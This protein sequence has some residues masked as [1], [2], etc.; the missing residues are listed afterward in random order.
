MAR[1]VLPGLRPAPLASYLAGLGLIRMLGEQADPNLTARWTDGGLV[2]TTTVEDTAAWL[3]DQYVPTPVLSPWNEGSGFGAKDRTPKQTLA[4]LA[5]HPSPRLDA[6]RRALP[7]ATSVGEKYR[8]SAGWTKA[9]AVREF[10]N[11]CPDEL[12]PWIDAAVVLAADQVHFPPLLGT[13]GNDGRLD[14]STTFH[15]RLLDVLDP[16]IRDRARS[17]GQARDL[18]AGTQT[19]RLHR[20]PVGQFDPAAAG[21]RSSSP[22]G[23]ADSV[24]NPWQFILLVEGALLFASSATRRH[25]HAAGRAAMPFTVFAAPDGSAS[26]AAGETSRGEVW[27]PVWEE[28]FTLAEVRQLFA[29]ARASWRGR[30]ARQAVEFYAATRTLG[31]A[32]GVTG[33]VRYGLHQRNGLAYVAVPVEHLTVRSS[34]EV[35]LAARLEDWASWL[36]RDV[37]STVVG[38]AV[39]GFDAAHLSFARDGGP[40]SLARLL[41]AVTNLELAVGRSGRARDNARVRKPPWAH[42]F[43]PVLG[44]AECPELRVAVGIASCTTRPGPDAD[45]QPARSMRQIL[46]PIDPD[47][48]WRDTPVIAGYG[49]RPLRTVLADVLIWRSRTATQERHHS[50]AFRGTPT[51]RTGIAVP[52]ADLHAFATPGQLN[53]DL[54]DLWLRACLALRWDGVRHEWADPGRPPVPMPTLGL[55]HPFAAGLAPK[56]DRERDTPRL[57]LGPDWAARLAAGQ[58]TTVHDDA[59][60]RLRQAGWRAVPRPEQIH[61]DGV[62]IAAAL[63]P[64]CRQP[65][66]VLAC[67]LAT[68]IRAEEAADTHMPDNPDDSV[69]QLVEESS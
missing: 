12:L 23:G 17:L 20:A 65:Q 42:D 63:V 29:E 27:A 47:L 1:H 60:R 3:V 46:L 66:R 50:D 39:R 41:A 40:L 24:V 6:F 48:R 51:F 5:A 37:A 53:D 22:F 32:R 61:A 13:G 30:P 7:A 26:G 49:L 69:P 21:G 31:V 56:L 2:L 55:F 16:A 59:V 45:R 9:R 58:L 68:P 36:R 54:L 18:V 43:L 10:R 52:D 62:A 33:F 35:R 38:R 4:A 64:R 34:P 44:E 19:Q 67:H 28:P 14:F 8:S 57:G 11:R 15:Q 25:Q